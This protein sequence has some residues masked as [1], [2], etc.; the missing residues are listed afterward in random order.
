VGGKISKMLNAKMCFY[1]SGPEG[2][3]VFFLLAGIPDQMFTWLVHYTMMPV[4]KWKRN[5]VDSW[6]LVICIAISVNCFL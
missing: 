4:K 6:W 1:F 2:C 5:V 3:V